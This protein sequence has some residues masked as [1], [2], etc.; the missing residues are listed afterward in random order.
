MRL[1]ASAS[2]GSICR[3]RPIDTWSR[4]SPI[5]SIESV[6]MLAISSTSAPFSRR[7]RPSMPM[8]RP[9]AAMVSSM[10]S[11]ILAS[12]LPGDLDIHGLL[13]GVEHFLARLGDRVELE[14]DEP[15]ALAQLR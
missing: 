9:N 1:Q 6:P 5:D 12:L 14:W 7:R 3:A 13:Q 15:H 8:E 10:S 11:V 2:G 4:N